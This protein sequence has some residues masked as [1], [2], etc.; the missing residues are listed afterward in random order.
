M[1]GACVPRSSTRSSTQCEVC[2][3]LWHV[4]IL[5]LQCTVHS[6]QCYHTEQC[7]ADEGKIDI[8]QL[9]IVTACI[10]PAMQLSYLQGRNKV[11]IKRDCS[12]AGASHEQAPRFQYTHCLQTTR[13]CTTACLTQLPQHSMQ[14]LGQRYSKGIRACI[15]SILV[16]ADDVSP[17]FCYELHMTLADLAR[18]P[19]NLNLNPIGSDRQS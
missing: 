9:R 13:L 15:L 12:R 4:T 3:E 11:V 6:G 5:L 7:S 19:G 14:S 18:Q 10:I 17:C 8:G 1:T 16:M 2:T